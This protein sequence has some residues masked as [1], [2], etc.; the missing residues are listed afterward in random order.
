MNNFPDRG[1][2]PFFLCRELSNS[3]T[4]SPWWAEKKEPRPT[5][6]NHMPWHPLLGLKSTDAQNTRR[7][8]A[9]LWLL[10]PSKSRFLLSQHFLRTS[11]EWFSGT[12]RVKMK[13]SLLSQETHYDVAGKTLKKKHIPGEGRH[14]RF[15]IEWDIRGKWHWWWALKVLAARNGSWKKLYS[16]KLL[17]NM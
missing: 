10:L 4:P 1:K 17:A 8:L 11:L 13:N 5:N 7:S 15:C 12:G 16:S 9:D 2:A 3:T 14:R 6:K